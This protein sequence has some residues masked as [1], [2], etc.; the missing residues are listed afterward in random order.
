[1]AAALLHRE[2]T[3]HAPVVDVSLLGMGVWGNSPAII[4]SVEQGGPIRKA[5]REDNL[6]PLSLAYRTADD[7]FLKLSLLQSDRFFE[8]FCV[9]LGVAELVED[10]RFVDAGARTEHRAE[11]T[12]ALDAIFERL[13]LAEVERRFE[14]F[15]G[16]WSTVRSTYE[17]SQDPQVAAN[18]YLTDVDVDGHKVTIASSPWQFDETRYPLEPAPEHGAQTDEILL[19]LGFDYDEILEHKIAGTVL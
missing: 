8:P 12:G 4:A 7:R 5:S 10:P 2:R 16:P 17:V 11:L 18:G 6:N 14:G 3:G 9:C 1:M 15:D 19:E 13:T